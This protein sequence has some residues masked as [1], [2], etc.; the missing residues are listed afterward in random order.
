MNKTRSATALLVAATGILTIATTVLAVDFGPTQS[1]RT[2]PTGERLFVG[3]IAAEE[4]SDRAVAVV[5]EESGPG[6]QHSYL[7]QSDDSGAT[8]APRDALR[9]GGQ[10]YD[11]QV[12]ACQAGIYAVSTWP[13]AS[14]SPKI[15]L[16]FR[17]S[18]FVPFSDFSIALH[19]ARGVDPD[20]ACVGAPWRAVAWFDDSTSPPH[21][22]LRINHLTDVPGKG[23]TE[24]ELD[25]GPARLRHSLSL[26]MTE[27]M[28]YVAFKPDSRM[29]LRRFAIAYDPFGDGLTA[30]PRPTTTIL[31]SS[32]AFR[33]LIAADGRD[34]ALAYGFRGD[35]RARMS[36]DKGN[37]F[38]AAEILYEAPCTDCEAGSNPLSIDLLDSYVVVEAVA[39]DPASVGSIGFLS[40][41]GGATWSETSTPANA[42]QV[43]ALLYDD[44]DVVVAEAWDNSALVDPMDPPPARGRLRFHRG[45]L[46]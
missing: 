3:D 6:G 2:T 35:T 24:V 20:I 30:T 42:L 25:L 13:T 36:T 5:W 10:A 4:A 19:D 22:M 15:G 33:P 23:P 21:V 31:D 1:L 32:A 14:G 29:V 44:S 27:R 40:D 11:P 9:G 39:G 43:G 18:P 34:V 26:A 45:V 16:D 46:P 12:A 17:A 38:G 37:T 7:R 41:D 8:F 28:V